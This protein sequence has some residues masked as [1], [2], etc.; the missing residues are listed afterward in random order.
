MSQDVLT[1]VVVS[2]RLVRDRTPAVGVSLYESVFCNHLPLRISSREVFTCYF[3][4]VN[5]TPGKIP[6]CF[7]I[8][9]FAV[10]AVI[11]K[12]M[13]LLNSIYELSPRSAVT[14]CC[15][16]ATVWWHTDA[17]PLRSSFVYPGSCQQARMPNHFYLHAT[18]K[19]FNSPK[20]QSKF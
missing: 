18:I 1:K 12:V 8:L 19:I 10:F 2:E 6:I 14:N 9:S 4:Q 20:S 13:L 11:N 15:M 5:F 17:L 3:V 16:R 7:R